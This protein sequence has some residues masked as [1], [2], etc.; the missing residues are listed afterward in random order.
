[1]QSRKDP[2]SKEIRFNTNDVDPSHV[3]DRVDPDQADWQ[4]IVHIRRIAQRESAPQVN[5]T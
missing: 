5:V 4:I 3:S 1:M 2:I